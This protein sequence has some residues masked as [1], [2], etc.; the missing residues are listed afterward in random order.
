[1][2]CFPNS[3]G[4]EANF[5]GNYAKFLTCERGKT[6]EADLIWIVGGVAGT[7]PDRIYLGRYGEDYDLL[8][9]PWWFSHW[10]FCF[11]GGCQS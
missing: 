5:I 2:S 1:M 6:L 8:R 7:T 9:V 3:Q 11:F 4:D 10:D